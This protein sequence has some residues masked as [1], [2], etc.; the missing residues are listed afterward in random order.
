MLRFLCVLLLGL[1]LTVSGVAQEAATTQPTTQPATQP[2]D[3]EKAD[4]DTEAERPKL[5]LKHMTVNREGRYVDLEATVVLRK[6][7]WLELLACTKGTKEHESI[8]TVKATP[9]HIHLG[10]LLIGLKP[11]HPLRWAPGTEDTDPRVEAP[12]GDKVAVFIVEERDGK[13]FERPANEWII[14]QKTGKVMDS[15]VWLFTGSTMIKEKHSERRVYSA[16]ETGT[17]LTLVSFGDDVMAQATDVT[18]ENDEGMWGPRTILIPKEGTELTLRL[19][20]VEEAK[21]DEPK[22]KDGSD[23]SQADTPATQPTTQPAAGD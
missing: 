6:G 11:G 12:K 9:R 14:N 21:A 18:N 2:A 3:G 23:K 5:E 1:S 8:L 15:N 16:D 10:L 20:P 7:D 22:K 4:T 17:V 19:R 13:P